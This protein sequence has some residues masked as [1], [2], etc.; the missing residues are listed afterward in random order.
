MEK[1]KIKL[2]S[3]KSQDDEKQFNKSVDDEF[4]R[5]MDFAKENAKV[6]QHLDLY[7]QAVANVYMRQKELPKRLNQLEE[8]YNTPL[9]LNLPQTNQ[10]KT[11]ERGQVLMVDD[12][13]NQAYVNPKDVQRLLDTKRASIVQ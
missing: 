12:Q 5:L 9:S 8:F 13:G 3:K 1:E 11:N 2:E 6:Y 7:R 4:K 10:Y